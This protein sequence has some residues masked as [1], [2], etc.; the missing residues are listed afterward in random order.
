[1]HTHASP[2]VLPR[3]LVSMIIA[4]TCAVEASGASPTLMNAQDLAADSRTM[5]TNRQPMLI[6]YSQAGCTWC[7]EARRYIVPMAIDP[8]TRGKAVF[9]QINIDSDAQ[10][11]DFNGEDSTHRAFAQTRKISLTPTVVLHG[12][13]GQAMG[14][15]I[16]GM[17]LP[18]F[19]G[20]YLM[21][22]IESARIKIE[23]DTSNPAQTTTT[24]PD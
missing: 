1:M 3:L 8:T 10:L 18:D 7:E 23:R 20:Q 19:Y 5:R 9:R 11:I 17:R 12:P 2:A 15:A 22:A 13:D 24:N 16:I 14:E 6:L 21:N 4:I